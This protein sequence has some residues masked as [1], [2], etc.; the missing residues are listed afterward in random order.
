ME[1]N[2]VHYGDLIKWVHK[3]I[4]SCQTRGQ[5]RTA[6]RLI[7]N[8]TLQPQ[9]NQLDTHLYLEIISEMRHKCID[10]SFEMMEKQLNS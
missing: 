3:V 10:M 2:K 6:E 7:D 8:L 9:I 4:D 1:N 5:I